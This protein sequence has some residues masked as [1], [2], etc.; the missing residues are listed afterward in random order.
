MHNLDNLQCDRGPRCLPRT[1]GIFSAQP[2][3][4][5]Q[6]KSLTIGGSS[7]FVRCNFLCQFQP[8][9]LS[10]IC[11]GVPPKPSQFVASHASFTG[12][13]VQLLLRTTPFSIDHEDQ[14]SLSHA[15]CIS[16]DTP[17]PP[18][19]R[20]FAPSSLCSSQF[21][22]FSVFTDSHVVHDMNDSSGEAS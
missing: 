21:A 18:I 4:L 11:H 2:L 10:T 19:L 16:T 8:K 15:A 5:F 20:W 7:F 22:R 3:E 6:L 12:C 9:E 14:D 13:L 1:H 17:F